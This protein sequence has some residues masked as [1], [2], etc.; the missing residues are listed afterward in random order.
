MSGPDRARLT[1]PP[2]DS[3]AQANTT[4]P[5]AAEPEIAAEDVND[6]EIGQAQGARGN[7]SSFLFMTIMLFMLTNNGGVSN[8]TTYSC[9]SSDKAV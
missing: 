5:P 6:L 3:P 4:R 1:P 8:E 2:T 7:M 9:V